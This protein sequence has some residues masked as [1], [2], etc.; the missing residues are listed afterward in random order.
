[1]KRILL[2]VAALFVLIVHPAVASSDSMNMNIPEEYQG[3]WICDDE[4]LLE[5]KLLME[6]T[7]SDIYFNGMPFSAVAHDVSILD[8]AERDS[9][10]SY[11]V[12][13]QYMERDILFTSYFVYALDSDGRLLMCISTISD[14]EDYSYPQTSMLLFDR[15]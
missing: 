1:M 14:H 6:I 12:I 10:A 15:L 13:I 5:D 9:G 4:D 7:A 8:Y 3:M 2:I 11:S